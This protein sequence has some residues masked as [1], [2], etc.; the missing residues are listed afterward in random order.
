MKF[1]YSDPHFGHFN[2]IKYS[3]RPFLHEVQGN[4]IV[5]GGKVV[6]VNVDEKIIHKEAERLSV[7]L[8]T[9]TLIQRWNSVVKPEDEVWIVGDF[10]M[11]LDAKKQAEVLRR[12]NGVKNLILGNHD[13][14]ATAMKAIGFNECFYEHDLLLKNG[15]KLKLSH[16]PYVAL[17]LNKMAE[18]RPNIIKFMKNIKANPDFNLSYELGLEKLKKSGHILPY[19]PEL[20]DDKQTQLNQLKKV[21]SSHIGTRLVNK[22]EI[23]G[24][25][26]THHPEKRFANMI[27]FSVEAWDYT[28]VSED[29]VIALM[30]EIEQEMNGELLTETNYKDPQYDYYHSLYDSLFA[31]K[32][33]LPEKFP[34][35]KIIH[36]LVDLYSRHEYLQDNPSSDSRLTPPVKYSSRW[37]QEAVRLD[38]FIPQS[39]LVAGE[40]YLGDCRNSSW[41]YYTGEKFIYWRRKFG[42]EFLEA[43][44]A[45]ENDCGY[46][47]FVP[48]KKY[49]ISD[50]ERAEFN[51][52]LLK[53]NQK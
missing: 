52:A 5:F 41:A 21:I 45:V 17:E 32:S 29:R 22:G 9:E 51:Q 33:G 24:H 2:V 15:K 28:P 10:S 16:Y 23:M 13:R 12:L 42:D 39:K 36:D 30:T 3:N 27:N 6:A 11:K 31:H 26:H 48:H 8:M 37:Y 35:L 40:F 1:L 38:M 50:E 25:G 43:I 34:G 49:E 7:E 14:K 4:D 47:V 53:F 44:E 19:N 20:D 18:S 46:D